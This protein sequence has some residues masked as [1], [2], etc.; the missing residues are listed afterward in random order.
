[1]R[2][3]PWKVSIVALAALLA[4]IAGAQALVPAQ[5]AAL[6]SSTTGSQCYLLPGSST[7]GV[8][9]NGQPCSIID[10]SGGSGAAV[11]PGK[12]AQPAVI[13]E[14]IEVSGTAPW[15]TVLRCLPPRGGRSRHSFQKDEGPRAP[16][17][18][19]TGAETK[20]SKEEVTKRLKECLSILKEA[21]EE[22]EPVLKR[23][24]EYVADLAAKG[25]DP[26]SPT[27]AADRVHGET[28]REEFRRL[29]SHIGLGILSW[30]ASE[31]GPVPLKWRVILA[32]LK[33]GNF[34]S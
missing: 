32:E 13:G 27:G 10:G 33:R 30:E 5:A 12:S 18:R 17:G 3:K 34:P 25:V 28:L 16:G 22:W 24:N 21:R 15:C 14:V 31:C 29:K 20:R 2:R 6:I 7:V 1:M 8:T 26:Y 11:Q 23:W 19:G 9:A 4:T